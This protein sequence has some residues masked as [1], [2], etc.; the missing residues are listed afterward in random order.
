MWTFFS[1]DPQDS[2]YT[3][4]QESG[5]GR[6]KLSGG[7]SLLLHGILFSV[8]CW[9]A[10]PSFVK[11]NLVARGEAGSAA[12]SVVALYLPPDS[13]LQRP[14]DLRNVV[15]LPASP[16]LKS[17]PVSKKRNNVL[18]ADKT[19]G[20]R[21]LGSR[22]GSSFDGPAEGDEVKPA[23]PVV[24]ADPRVAK[25]ELPNGLQGDVIVEITIDERG[26]VI[27]ERLLQGLGHGIDER[28][29]A[30]VRDWRFSP[31][32]RNGVPVP[33]KHDVHFHFPS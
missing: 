2:P 3:L 25:W 1:R 24:F 31:A 19:K 14:N 16:K 22:N 11:P 17:K 20:D 10:A 7:I 13:Q 8:L 28:V 15:T 32:T 29:I 4:C 26:T 5:R 23:L 33:S 12:P 21:E 9:P 18:E 30:A 27:G 6:G